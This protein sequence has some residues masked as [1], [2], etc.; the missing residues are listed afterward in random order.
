MQGSL[1]NFHVL[2]CSDYYLRYIH[3]DYHYVQL[4]LHCSQCHT[5]V[6]DLHKEDSP[7]LEGNKELCQISDYK[8]PNICAGEQ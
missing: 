6:F 5:A 7:N 1:I 2:R 4:I 3:P 8:K